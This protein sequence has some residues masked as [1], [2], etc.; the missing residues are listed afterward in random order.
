MSLR[1]IVLLVLLAFAPPAIAQ[2]SPALTADDIIADVS[3]RRI[4]I[5]VGFSGADTTL[6]GALPENGDVI[7]TVTGPESV[8]RVRRKERTLGVWLNQGMVEYDKVPGFY[9]IAASRPLADIAPDSWL[10]AQHLGVDHLRF[11]I[12]NASNYLDLATFRKALI[13]LRIEEGL[14]LA[15][16]A[17]ASVMGG[18]LYRADVHI[19]ANAP[20]GDYTVTTYLLQAGELVGT[21]KTSLTLRKE[22]SMADVS[23]IA[24]DYAVVYAILALVLAL[25]AGWSSATLLQRS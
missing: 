7:L 3:D 25:L 18:R 20:T 10:T 15:E 5:T 22:G 12:R 6:F 14:F 4:A 24:E 13:D 16:P 9:W 1:L 21:Q 2:E 8:V 11:I 19:P 23:V 17:L